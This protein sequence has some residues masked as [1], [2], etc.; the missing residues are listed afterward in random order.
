M[1]KNME[2]FGAKSQAAAIQKGPNPME[3][4]IE[5]RDALQEEVKS[6]K[7]KKKPSKK[8]TKKAAE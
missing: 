7:A 3:A 5:E 4:V 6:L 2:R 8:K 1:F